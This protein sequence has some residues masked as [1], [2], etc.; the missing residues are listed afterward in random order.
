MA[1]DPFA[2][3]AGDPLEVDHDELATWLQSAVERVQRS[4]RELE[5]MIGVAHER[6]V[7]GVGR[8][9]AGLLGA[10]HQADV[11]DSLI[12]AGLVDVIQKGLCD[13]HGVDLALGPHFLGEQPREEPRA[14]ADV[15]NGHAGFE[16][17]G[18][19]DLLAFA[20]DFAA[21]DLE[22]SQESFQV[23]VLERLVDVR[24]NALFLGG[25]G[26]GEKN[27]AND[28]DAPALIGLIDSSSA[29]RGHFRGQPVACREPFW[30]TG[31]WL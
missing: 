26:A 6:H 4:E 7:D 31:P 5:V 14:R 16:L 12:L 23:R 17:A 15:G 9:L 10:L 13:V 24:P 21:L 20:V 25:E 18:L 1:E 22:L 29:Q 19:D 8:Q 30:V 28:G 11:L 3:N 27:K 2:T